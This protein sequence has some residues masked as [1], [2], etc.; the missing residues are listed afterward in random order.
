MRCATPKSVTYAWSPSSRTLAGL[1]SRWSTP[2]ACAA[3]NALAI[4]TISATARRTSNGPWATTSANDGPSISRI[5]MYGTP[6][7]T[8]AS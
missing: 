5:A 3:S 7:T 1:T 8:P 2:R 6:S 4:C